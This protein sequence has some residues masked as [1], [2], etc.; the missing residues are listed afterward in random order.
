MTDDVVK[1]IERAVNSAFLAYL[2]QRFPDRAFN[3]NGQGELTV[4][5]IDAGLV[6]TEQAVS[7]TEEVAGHWRRLKDGGWKWI[8]EH[9]RAKAMPTAMDLARIEAQEEQN[10]NVGFSV[11]EALN[12]FV[13]TLS[14]PSSLQNYLN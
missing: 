6:R 3:M 7:G 12:G 5:G 11:E 13:S 4:D 8:S 2:K 10:P 1:Q 9:S 14:N